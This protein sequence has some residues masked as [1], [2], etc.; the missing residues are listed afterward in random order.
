MA[1]NN[2]APSSLLSDIL[3]GLYVILP[4]VSWHLCTSP[5]IVHC[6]NRVKHTVQEIR[7]TAKHQGR[8]LANRCSWTEVEPRGGRGFDATTTQ[9]G[10]CQ[11]AH[12][13]LQNR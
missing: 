6:H 2:A 4:E 13:L 3:P 7:L 5:S 1:A 11:E 8:L 10:E 12:C 9:H